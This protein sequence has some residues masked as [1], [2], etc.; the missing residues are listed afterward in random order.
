MD[1]A[2]I[3]RFIESELKVCDLK[4]NSSKF[5]IGQW[6]SKLIVP[7]VEELSIL[8]RADKNI[9]ILS[10]RYN[11]LANIMPPS[12][13]NTSFQRIGEFIADNHFPADKVGLLE[14]CILN[15][16]TDSNLSRKSQ[17]ELCVAD[18]G[19]LLRIFDIS[20]LIYESYKNQPLGISEAKKWRRNELVSCWENVSSISKFQYQKKYNLIARLSN[21]T[22]T[23]RCIFETELEKALSGLVEDAC[24]SEKNV[25]GY[26]IWENHIEPMVSI[27]DDLS[28]LHKA[29]PEI[30]RIATLL[31]DLAGIED[32]AKA[33][34][35]HIHGADRARFLLSKAGYPDD[36]TELIA[37][38]I[39]HHRGSVAMVKATPEEKALADADA[40][41]H[42]SDL[43]SLF[44]VAY[45]K[46]NLGFEEGRQWVL[47]KIKRDWL[48]MSTIA[49]EQYRNE[50]EEIVNII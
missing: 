7:L 17:E 40:V 49:K 8:H 23:D 16:N 26:G 47:Q 44:Y 31:H 10:V 6:H 43:P 3:D 19:F 32:H 5:E 29:D 28:S 20:S 45:V 14:R 2:L 33:K 12:D 35:H 48:K 36:K 18:A 46:Q 13:R 41:A 1:I 4:N 22:Y 34:D 27:A 9:V 11:D 24:L 39:L 25:Y 37:Q 15:S 21:G 38:C 50:F 30:V 42:M